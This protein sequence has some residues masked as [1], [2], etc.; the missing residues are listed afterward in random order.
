MIRKSTIANVIFFIIICY[1]IAPWY[2]ERTFYLNELIAITGLIIL[3]YKRFRT[4]NDMISLCII[5]LL[6]WSALH[7]II[8]L[9]RQDSMYYYLRNA[10]IVYSVFAFFIGFYL[11]KYFTDFLALIR[12]W[13]LYFISP[14]LLIK[15]PPMIFERFGV[16]SLFPVLFKHARNRFFPFLLILLNLLY[17]ITYSSATTFII[18]CFLFLV[19][20][21]PGY[22]F[23]KQSVTIIIVSFTLLFFYL[24]PNL[25]L[26][27]NQFDITSDNAIREVER[28]HPLLA[29][30]PNTTWRL[31]IWKQIIT[32]NFPANIFGLGF[33]TPMIRYY[34]VEDFNKVATLPYVLGA[35]NSFIYLFGRLGLVF[36]L[37]IVPIYITVFKE[38]FYHRKY[39]YSNNQVL[40]FLS[41]FSI[42]VMCL[43]NPVLESSIFASGYWFLLGLTARCIYNRKS[44]EGK[45]QMNS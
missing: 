32:D 18:A 27:K 38:Y 37:L 24:Q 30:D 10:V 20:I 35:H 28:S 7:L 22:R 33:G 23:F 15:A 43:F 17:A 31:V 34:P 13:L 40:L 12:R 21:S 5:L 26:I 16:S 29:I 3:G 8:S 25:S 41:F 45:T 19:F 44:G 42:T 6:G 36:I 14:F 2:L 4:G 39:Y 1:I 11:L 9:L